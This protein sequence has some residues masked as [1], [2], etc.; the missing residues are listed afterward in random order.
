MSSIPPLHNLALYTTGGLFSLLGCAC[1][2]HTFETLSK[3]LKNPAMF[4][5]LVQYAFVSILGGFV[6]FTRNKHIG[7]SE[8]QI[9]H[10]WGLPKSRIPLSSL[11]CSSAIYLISAVS[12]QVAYWFA[13]PMPFHI[14]LRSASMLVT[15]GLG[16][17][18]FNKTF[19]IHHYIS[20]ILATVGILLCSIEPKKR[21]SII[22]NS[23]RVRIEASSDIVSSTNAN[24][25]EF[26]GI[27]HLASC[28]NDP[29]PCNSE[30]GNIHGITSPF[31]R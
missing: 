24:R 22:D 13:V 7:N 29:I 9:P 5:M 23:M 10:I 3:L 21:Q 27:Y 31:C 2:Y 11:L 19:K 15:M 18:R 26:G 8:N 28:L 16:I 6:A 25:T 17:M 30:G 1:S 12:G 4:L 20:A 14:I